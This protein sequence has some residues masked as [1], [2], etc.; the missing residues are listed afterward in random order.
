V[1]GHLLVDERGRVVR[2]HRLV[3]TGFI[4][5]KEEQFV[6]DDRTTGVQVQAL[7]VVLVEACD[8]F[9]ISEEV[10]VAAALEE[11]GLPHRLC[12]ELELIRARAGDGVDN[13]AGSAAELDGVAAGLHL[14]LFVERIRHRGEANPVVEVSDIQAV[15]VNGILGHGRTS[16]R[17]AAEFAPGHACGQFRDRQQVAIDRQPRKFHLRQV[18][19]RL[20]GADVN[21]VH[22]ARCDDLDLVDGAR[23]YHCRPA[24]VDRYRNT[25]RDV[26]T[27]LGRVQC[28]NAYRKER[29]AEAAV[30]IRGYGTAE[31]GAPVTHDDLCTG[32]RTARHRAIL[33]LCQ[34]GQRQGREGHR[35]G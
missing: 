12:P 23:V 9:G 13:T 5:T 25:G 20:R 29:K 31:S 27:V 1:V 24:Q 8:V 21:Y 28:V 6:L 14:E 26:V 32:L 17:N 34:G 3:T 7:P 16:E 15:D 33:R 11:G 4:H 18:G 10:V 35:Q 19:C 2:I 30:R 22:A